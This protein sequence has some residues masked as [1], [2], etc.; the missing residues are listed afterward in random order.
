MLSEPA[1]ILRVL[2]D[3]LT[4]R[5]TRYASVMEALAQLAEAPATAAADDV[6]EDP[7]DLAALDA[8]WEEAAVQFGPGE[9]LDGCSTDRLRT[10][11]RAA[12]RAV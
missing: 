12:A 8:A 7:D 2:A 5:D 3:R 4:G 1:S 9:M 11:L 10:R 6:E